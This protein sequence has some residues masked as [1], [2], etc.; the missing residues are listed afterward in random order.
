MDFYQAAAWRSGFFEDL[1]VSVDHGGAR[2][3][4]VGTVYYVIGY[5]LQTIK[6]NNR[7]K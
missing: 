3:E 6:D 4:F 7:R 2:L 5:D 1:M